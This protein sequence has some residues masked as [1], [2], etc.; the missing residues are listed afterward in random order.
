MVNGADAGQQE[1]RNAC[2]F[3]MRHHGFEVFLVGVRRKPIAD[4]ST[5]KTIAVRYFNERHAG[6]V[7]RYGDTDHLLERDLVALRMHA[8]AQAIVMQYDS[9]A[10]QAHSDASAASGARG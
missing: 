10:A 5:A 6:S 3:H 9:S 8:I 7:H 1:C 4:G 2:L